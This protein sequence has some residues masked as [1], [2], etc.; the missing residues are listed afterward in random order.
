MKKIIYILFPLFIISCSKGED[1]KPS[2]SDQSYSAEIGDIITLKGN[3]LG[4]VQSVT[5]FSGEYSVPGVTI[6]E[7][8]RGSYQNPFF[9]KQTETEIQFVLPELYADSYIMRVGDQEI[10]L[11]IKGFIP[12]NDVLDFQVDKLTGVKLIDENK[13]LVV[14]DRNLYQLDNGYH[15]VTLISR[16]VRFYDY[17]E[18]GDSWYAKISDGEFYEIHYSDAGNSSYNLLT[19]FHRR[20]INPIGSHPS[21][22]IITP[23]KQIF[24]SLAN[25][26]YVKI[27][28]EIKSINDVYP[29]FE[30]YSEEER[31][32]YSFQLTPSG[33]VY[34]RL[35]YGNGYLSL[36]PGDST[37]VFTEKF[38]SMP[39]GPIFRDNIGYLLLP[40][41]NRLYKSTDS[42]LT[43]TESSTS[44]PTH[45]EELW[46]TKMNVIDANTILLF[47][48]SSTG[49]DFPYTIAYITRDG[50]NT[51]QERKRFNGPR[52]IDRFA[53]HSD[54]KEN[55]GLVFFTDTY[56]QLYK[57][58]E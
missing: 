54:L 21:D 42:G 32:I 39:E 48:H 46:Y 40:W 22:I 51:W 43:W 33:T 5:I 11:N 41:E 58:V 27:N 50:G 17:L 28:D 38:T 15:D 55:G 6:V 4:G 3:N 10:P 57:Y 44:T 18:N 26:A 23:E 36:N 29:G 52:E 31:E 7:E 30:A 35:N 12:L 1:P 2:L 14:R 49:Y 13:A 37:F 53:Q 9:T 20:D 25:K 24:F 34:T 8:S 56:S 16:N 47:V 19:T 45:G